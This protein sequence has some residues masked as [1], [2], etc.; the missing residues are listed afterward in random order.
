MGDSTAEFFGELGRRGHEPLLEK[1]TAI[2]RLDLGR[3]E[4]TDRWF[5]TIKKGDLA[6]SRKS[7]RAGC[8]IRTTKAVFD[9]LA[10]G[11]ANLMAA[12]LRGEVDVDGDV[13]L[14]VLFRR[15]F[16]GPPSSHPRS[17]GNEG[18]AK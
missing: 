10:R 8:T 3:G 4:Q 9:R 7:A 14:L 17:H 12:T 11:E 6:V 13:T 2:V 18:R 16:P 1:A 5:V 15:L